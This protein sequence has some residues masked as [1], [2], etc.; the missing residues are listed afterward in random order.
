MPIHLKSPAVSFKATMPKTK[1]TIMPPARQKVVTA[2]TLPQLMAVMVDTEQIMPQA[3]V[4]NAR[5]KAPQ[6][7]CVGKPDLITRKTELTL[8]QIIR[9]QR[10]TDRPPFVRRSNSF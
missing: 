5:K 10:H 7:N 2:E 8:Q 4:K 6:L 9:F 3:L 1:G